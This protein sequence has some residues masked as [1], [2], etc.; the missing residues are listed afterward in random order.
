LVSARAI[1]GV[2]FSESAVPLWWRMLTLAWVK[3]YDGSDETQRGD[4]EK[5]NLHAKRASC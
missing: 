4:G 5:G 3:E 1:S 2:K